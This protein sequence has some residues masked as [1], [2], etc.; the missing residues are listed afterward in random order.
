MIMG[1]TRATD[2]GAAAKFNQSLFPSIGLGL[3]RNEFEVTRYALLCFVNSSIA[4]YTAFI[5]KL[6]YSVH[7]DQ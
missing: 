1:H 4:A 3:V 5:R 7:G 2:E 6:T